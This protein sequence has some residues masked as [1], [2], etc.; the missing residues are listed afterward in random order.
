MENIIGAGI[1]WLTVSGNN[2][3]QL[4]CAADGAGSL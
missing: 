1:A 2:A 3:R 4:V